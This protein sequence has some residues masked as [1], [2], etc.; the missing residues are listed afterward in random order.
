MNKIVREHHKKMHRISEKKSIEL[1]LNC[2]KKALKYEDREGIALFVEIH[3]I[4]F[5]SSMHS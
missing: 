5:I 2:W 4:K 1:A 3:Y